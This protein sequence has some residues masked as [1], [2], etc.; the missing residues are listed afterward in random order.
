MMT[1]NAA[2]IQFKEN[3]VG[4]VHLNIIRIA[5]QGNRGTPYPLLKPK[6]AGRK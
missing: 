1:I 2:A 5:M 6:K 3:H 4:R